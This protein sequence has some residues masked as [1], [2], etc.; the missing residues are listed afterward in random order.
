MANINHLSN[1]NALSQMLG[2]KVNPSEDIVIALAGNPNTGKSTLFNT[3]TGLKQHT[4]N[5]TGKTVT[6]ALGNYKFKDKNFVLVDLPGTYSLLSSSVEEE[7]A[8]DFICFA[9]PNATVVVTDSTCLER[10]LNLVLQ[11]LE[12]T[13][14]VVVCVNLIDEAER[15]KIRVDID[16]LSNL[17]GVPVVATNA[18][19]GKGLEDLMDA[20][21]KVSYEKI[22]SNPIKI[23][24][25]DDIEKRI[26]SLENKIDEFNNSSLS[27]RWIALKLLDEN[28][29]ILNSMNKYLNFDYNLLSLNRKED[30]DLRDDIVLTMISIAENISKEVVTFE[31]DSYNEFDRKIDDILTSKKFGIP[32]MIALLALTFWI[33]IEGANVPSEMLANIFNNLEKK[34]TAFFMSRGLEKL[35]GPLILGV[36]R[37]LGWVISVMLPPMAIF[38]PLFTLLEDLGYLPRVAFNLDNFFKKACAH[39]KQALTMCMGFGCNAAGVIGCRIID[40]P[41]ERLIAIITNTFVPC[42]G[43]FPI[44]ISITMI[45]I[46]SN[47]AGSFNGVIAALTVTFVIILGII[48]TLLSSRLL[49]KTLLKGEPSSFTLE[50]PPY[51]KPKV[52]QILVRSILDRTF[53]VLARAIIVAAPAGLIL[54]F[55]ANTYVGDNSVLQIC[56]NFLNPF[57]QAIGMDGYILLAFILGLPAN[58]IVIPIIIM[59]YMSAGALIEFQSLSTLRELLIANGWTIVTAINV[60]IFTLMHFPCGTTLLTIRKETGS[61]KWTLVSFLLPTLF[62]IIVCFLVTQTFALFL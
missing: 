29:N 3:L 6:T 57:A 30:K 43:R 56:A 24:Y 25:N 62:G 20:I 55:F 44:L 17:L 46:A 34:L 14:K 50:L 15:K 36:Y 19:N 13:D 52:G 21:Y 7:I 37:T 8:R 1:I 47:F 2:N 27:N 4:G 22:K 31:N 53:F 59:S 33:T 41:R 11:V 23:V 48:A 10:N 26:E 12:I 28:K 18:R 60:M 45:F 16:K 51:R 39:G 38:F 5:W 42:N 49:S 9:N 61:L 58:E 35:H 32:V 54:W 40:S